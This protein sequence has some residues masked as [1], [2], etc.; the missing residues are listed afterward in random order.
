MT[1]P[2]KRMAAAL[3]VARLILIGAALTASLPF[4]VNGRGAD[5]QSGGDT[6][7]TRLN[8]RKP[9]MWKVTVLS[10]GPNELAPPVIGLANCPGK[11]LTLH[12]NI[13]PAAGRKLQYAWTVNA[14]PQGGN[15][16]EFTFTPNNF[17]VFN[18]QVT[19]SDVTP[20]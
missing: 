3:L 15:T 18:V 4:A 14:P 10:F 6:P 19:I 2:L 9:K 17:G 13:A 20:P 1:R 12:A 11:P 7:N 5:V 16:P 8:P